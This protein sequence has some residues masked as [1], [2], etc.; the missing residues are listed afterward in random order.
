[1]QF[2]SQVIRSKLL[3]LLASTMLMN[4]VQAAT[5]AS[6]LTG[7]YSCLLNR[8]LV[9]YVSSLTGGSSIGVTIIANIDYSKNSAAFGVFMAD[10]FGK[11]N[12][13]GTLFNTAGTF[14]EIKYSPVPNAYKL[15][16]SIAD[17][18]TVDLMI[19]PVNAGNS[20]LVSTGERE[21]AK[22]PWSGVCQKI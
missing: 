19:M 5:T 9:P 10:N 2:I 17:G 22:A 16:V 21:A 13:A 12:A 1:M 18:S 20:L 6:G 14:T 7:Q 3:L 11:A 15:I 4:T 8:Q